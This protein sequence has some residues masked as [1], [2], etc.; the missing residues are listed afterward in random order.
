M[1]S[2]KYSNEFYNIIGLPPSIYYEPDIIPL[3]LNTMPI[4]ELTPGLP[5]YGNDV[6]GDNQGIKLFNFNEID[7]IDQYNR[8]LAGSHI[9]SGNLT[10][11]IKVAFLADTQITE[12]F[13]NVYGESMFEQAANFGLPFATELQY[14]TGKTDV[15][16]ALKSI[17]DRYNEGAGKNGKIDLGKDLKS[18]G[19]L[20]N[21]LLNMSEKISSGVVNQFANIAGTLQNLAKSYF[22]N[23]GNDLINLLSGHNIDFPMIWRG[24]N[25]TPN[26]SVT[27]KLY[28]PD[29][30]SEASYTRH[31]ID[32]LIK[33]LA[34][35]VP[36]ASPGAS[37]TYTYPVLCR[38]NC[39]GLFQI[40]SG[41]VSN[42]DVIKGGE[43]NDLSFQHRPGQIDVR[44]TFGSLYNSMISDVTQEIADQ[45][46][47]TLEHYI[48]NLKDKTLTQ[49]YRSDP[50]LISQDNSLDIE[51]STPETV[52]TSDTISFSDE[53]IPRINAERQSTYESLNFT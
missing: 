19:G 53:I 36:V 23:A 42:I 13:S 29:P 46:R 7:G 5:E 43:G 47:P 22:P 27:V 49:Y 30:Y 16:S 17:A 38:V 18:F 8:I 48:R 32:P 9:S 20:T 26:Y 24:S 15:G 33:L 21:A 4:M 31:I 6:G 10:F 41:Y 1:V 40:R 39:P 3:V 11:P 14:I 25:Y 51:D 28:N 12:S 34:F 44:M 2:T 35:V 37:S 45:D 50:A 52:I